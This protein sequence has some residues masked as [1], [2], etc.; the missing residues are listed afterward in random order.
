MTDTGYDFGSSS[1]S[2]IQAP[3]VGLLTGNDFDAL[4]V[5]EV[6]HFFEQE[7]KYPVT[8][9]NLD[10]VNEESLNEMDVLIVPNGW[11]ELDTLLLGAWV[12]NGGKLIVM[13]EAV[14]KFASVDGLSLKSKEKIE[15]TERD[16]YENAHAI[17]SEKDRQSITKEI[18]GAIYKCKLDPTNPLA[19][20]Y[21]DS[22]FTLK[23]SADAFELLPKGD[24]VAYLEDNPEAIAG[25][26]GAKA[27][28]T[29]DNSLIF[30][31]EY[32]GGGSIVYMV[33]SPLFRGFW[34]NGK[35]FFVNA[36]FF[37]NN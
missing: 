31:V 3:T 10:A 15:P 21:G 1:V 5:G 36:V 17:Y 35:L 4:A 29:Q 30:G 14:S 37:V 11:Y 25:F 24:N 9:L 26:V 2:L 28:K 33:D 18:K 22:Y 19:F 13:G 8:V 34:E 16:K 6:W 12:E 20:G 32:L 7:L 27:K 23:Q